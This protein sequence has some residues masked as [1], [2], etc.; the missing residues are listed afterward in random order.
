M[1]DLIQ[2]MGKEVVKQDASS[3]LGQY[4][5]L[6]NHEDIVNVLTTNSGSD[7]IKGII[8]PSK[9]LPKGFYPR[10][11]VILKLPN[12]NTISL[13]QP[14]QKFENLICMDLSLCQQL[15]QIPDVSGAPNIRD[16]KLEGCTNLKE[17]QD[18]VGGLTKVFDLSLE[19]CTSLE[20][21]P[22]GIQMTSLRLLNFNDCRSLQHFPDILEQMDKLKR[23]EARRTGIKQIPHSI[24][25][26]P[27]LEV[28]LLPHND[29]LVSI[30]E[31]VNK[32][33]RLEF[34]NLDNCRM[35]QQITG[36][37]SNLQQLQADGCISLTSQSSN[38]LWTQAL[39]EVKGFSIKMPITPI[40]DWFDHRCKGGSLSFWV[41]RKFPFF[42]FAVVLGESTSETSSKFGGAGVKILCYNNGHRIWS[43][44]SFYRSSAAAAGH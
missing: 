4:S 15:T 31:S 1:H 42:A 14:L 28:L 38:A 32:L 9:S 16:L 27:G 25:Y 6:W 17:I 35:L 37:P 18:S 3:K 21:F 24:C 2:D 26:L 43:N 34:F 12:G 36:I 7:C 20:I 40:P 8:Y 11:I 39:Q 23:F 22:H 10:K 29:N 33:D 44:T 13:K 5:R 19:E 41:R 30:P